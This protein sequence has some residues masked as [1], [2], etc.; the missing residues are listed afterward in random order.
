MT[1]KHHVNVEALIAE[2]YQYAKE[3]LSEPEQVGSESS[4]TSS[5]GSVYLL[6]SIIPQSVCR[7]CTAR[8]PPPLPH[9]TPPPHPPTHLFFCYKGI[10]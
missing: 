4:R 9:H 8:G 2:S 10:A 7:H 6:N 5:R 3:C 1:K